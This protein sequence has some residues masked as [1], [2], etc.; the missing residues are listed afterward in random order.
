MFH[1]E[2]WLASLLAVAGYGWANPNG[3]GQTPPQGWRSWNFMKQ[4]VSQA[5]IL[6]QVKALRLAMISSAAAIYRLC[7]SDMLKVY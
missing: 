7:I 6:A 1:A 4:D 5:K 2:L 3:L